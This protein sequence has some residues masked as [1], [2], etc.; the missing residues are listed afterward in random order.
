MFACFAQWA[1]SSLVS[2][3]QFIAIAHYLKPPGTYVRCAVSAIHRRAPVPAPKR[4]LGDR[5]RSKKTTDL[6][7]GG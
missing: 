6:N 7:Q 1:V 3:I 4:D 5:A 2:D